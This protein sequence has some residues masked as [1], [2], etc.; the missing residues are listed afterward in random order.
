M[1][2]S[3][4]NAEEQSESSENTDA[5]STNKTKTKRKQT[6]TSAF[7]TSK[8]EG[9][10][11][12]QFYSSNLYSNINVDEKQIII[13]NSNLFFLTKSPNIRIFQKFQTILCIFLF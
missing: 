1:K 6:K 9:H 4:K 2:K 3:I 8:R 7:G 12:T 5:I 13:D 11:A 10:D